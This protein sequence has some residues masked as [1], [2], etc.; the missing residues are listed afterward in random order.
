MSPLTTTDLT[1][2]RA[3]TNGEPWLVHT[4]INWLAT[5]LGKLNDQSA[6]L[7]TPASHPS[8]VRILEWGCGGSTSW[9]AQRSGHLTS[10]EHDWKWH[11]ATVGKNLERNINNIDHVFIPCKGDKGCFRAYAEFVKAFDE[12][13]FDLV[14][15]DG[16]A[17]VRCIEQ[18]LMRGLVKP[19]GVLV[20][21]NSER[22]YY[23]A[24][25]QII[26]NAGWSV[27]HFDDQWR[28]TIFQRPG[29]GPPSALA[30]MAAEQAGRQVG[31]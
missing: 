9:Y 1:G 2:K 10:I 22:R 21:D 11:A 28:T 27:Y 6:N 8:P 16:R 7:S 31:G 23:S 13:T 29:G 19:G 18:V 5:Y 20:L 30:R 24:A 25:R 26:A 3:W 14:N 17:R 12:N 4:A 15:V